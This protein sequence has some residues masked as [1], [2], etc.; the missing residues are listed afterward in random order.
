MWKLRL[1][2]SC[3]LWPSLFLRRLSL[4]TGLGSLLLLL[5]HLLLQE[6]LLL[7]KKLLFI[8]CPV[9]LLL[10]VSS[11]VIEILCIFLIFLMDFVIFD[12][13]TASHDLMSIWSLRSSFFQD[14]LLGL[15]IFLF[16]LL[17]F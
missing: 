15:D 4:T 2:F 1:L 13:L 14:H 9:V 16:C 6:H 8:I 3:T 17:L 11:L 7:Q 10:V 12:L 5:K